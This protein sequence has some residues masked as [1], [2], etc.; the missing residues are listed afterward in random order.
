MLQVFCQNILTD[1][2]DQL[3]YNIYIAK[4]IKTNDVVPNELKE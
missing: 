4:R 3:Y 1:T 2:V